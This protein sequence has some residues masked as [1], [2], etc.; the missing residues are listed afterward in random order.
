MYQHQRY[1]RLTKAL[2]FFRQLYIFG[3]KLCSTPRL[4]TTILG[5]LVKETWQPNATVILFC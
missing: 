5:V 1:I 4:D 2:N 3:T